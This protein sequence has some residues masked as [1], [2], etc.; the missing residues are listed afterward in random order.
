M[1]FTEAQ[2]ST[3]FR[4]WERKP[5]WLSQ[6]D[7]PLDEWLGHKKIHDVTR[8]SG[9]LVLEDVLS[10]TQQIRSLHYRSA[11]LHYA[12]QLVH[13]KSILH[14]TWVPSYILI[15]DWLSFVRTKVATCRAT[16]STRSV[17]VS[18]Y[19]KTFY[20]TYSTCTVSNSTYLLPSYE[21]TCV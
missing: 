19:I 6:G 10:L 20:H 4:S 16:C 14:N 18:C 7:L 3:Y 8:S 17:R 9:A 15:Y 13:N 12:G 21:S 5:L 1:W 11:A 2:L